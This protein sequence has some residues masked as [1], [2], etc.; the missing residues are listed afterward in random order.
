MGSSTAEVNKQDF[1]PETEECRKIIDSLQATIELLHYNPR[2][3]ISDDL[4][5]G[6]FTTD[7]ATQTDASE[8][9]P[10]KDLSSATQHLVQIIK[11]LQ[12]DFG[13]LKQFLQLQFEDRLKAES[14][15]LFDILDDKI[16]TA[17]RCYQQNEEQMRK[18]FNQQLADAIAVVKGTYTQF[19]QVSEEMTSTQDS[20][21]VKI[22]VL[23]RKLKEKERIIRELRGELEEYDPTSFLKLPTF[24]DSPASPL[25]TLVD[26][27]VL[28]WRVESERMTQIISELEDEIQLNL[29]EN[30]TLEDEIFSLKEMVEKDQKTIQKLMEA[31]ERIRVELENEKSLVQEMVNKQKENAETRKISETMGFKVLKVIKGQGATSPRRPVQ[32]RVLS[33]S[34]HARLYTPSIRVPP[35]GRRRLKGLKGL[36][37]EE[38]L[39]SRE[40]R[41]VSREEP[42][43]SREEPLVSKEEPLASR[44]ERLLIK[45]T[46][47]GDRSSFFTAGVK[48]SPQMSKQLEKML[49]IPEYK[50]EDGRNLEDE[51]EILKKAIEEE[52][53]RSERIKKEAEKINKTWERKFL[54]LR[55]RYSAPHT[56][57]ACKNVM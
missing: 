15:R 10:L 48:R 8:I 45:K 24:K 9:L 51:I 34:R 20:N 47:F 22:N 30:S 6:F 27:D 55:N 23:L 28:E 16:T 26:R 3:S 5:I 35:I 29:K 14:S 1:A 12:V 54:I 17:E 46:H 4:K 37:K 41:L 40:E 21:A 36:L 57:C 32:R 56:H 18:C 44:E 31:R 39:V 49:K 50:R 33:K 53:S 13:F 19:F 52:K 43:V 25:E 7:H 2:L 38:R 11:A 42:L